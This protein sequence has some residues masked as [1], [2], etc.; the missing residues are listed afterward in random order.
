MV[1]LCIARLYINSYY[2][3]MSIDWEEEVKEY[4]KRSLSKN[5]KISFENKKDKFIKKY[6]NL[7]IKNIN[8]DNITINCKICE[9]PYEINRSVLYHRFEITN[10]PCTL[11]NPIK[12][13]TSIAEKEIINN[14]KSLG[15]KVIENE[16]N[17]IKP[18]EID[19]YIL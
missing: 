15:I 11:C 8:N 16:R 1:L 2:S 18:F 6:E 5:R 13:G 10:N 12:S 9:K 4:K 19:I 7:D 14:I 3:N 17:I